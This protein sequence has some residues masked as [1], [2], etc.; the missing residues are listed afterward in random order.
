MTNI[1]TD[2]SFVHPKSS[3]IVTTNDA[4]D[5][6]VAEF[7][8]DVMVSGPI[9]DPYEK[10][11]EVLDPKRIE[12]IRETSIYN[13]MRIAVDVIACKQIARFE[14]IPIMLLR[15]GYFLK[16]CHQYLHALHV[17][18]VF[19]VLI[20]CYPSSCDYNTNA[21]C[22][23]RILIFEMYTLPSQTFS[24]GDSNLADIM[25]EYS[26]DDDDDN[27]KA[28]ECEIF[29]ASEYSTLQARFPLLL[30]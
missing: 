28:E 11:H 5:A 17:S 19:C 1:V 20:A 12:Q 25:S 24:Y 18:D 27:E 10:I 15:M 2:A 21:F 3:Y 26:R 23:S 30:Q 14:D 7:M 29:S 16:T 8:L 4:F 6:A 22:V 9:E 13:N